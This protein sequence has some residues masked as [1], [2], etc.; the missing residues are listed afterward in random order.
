MAALS[1][2]EP[3][4]GYCCVSCG[5]GISQALA[6]LGRFTATTAAME[7]ASLRC[8]CHCDIVASRPQDAI[9]QRRSLG[10]GKL[11][12]LRRDKLL[13]PHRWVE[14]PVELYVG[15]YELVT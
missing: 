3:E 11:A 2:S 5:G 13:R 14:R 4:S 9:P 1:W 15:A 7:A 6:R 10:S 12:S 8:A